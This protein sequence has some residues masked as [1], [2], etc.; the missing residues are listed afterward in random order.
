MLKLVLVGIVFARGS[1]DVLTVRTRNIG[2]LRLAGAIVSCHDELDI[3]ALAKAA[4]SFCIDFALMHKV[5]LI[6]CVG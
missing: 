1:L 4:E 3:F 5:V 6:T 2:G